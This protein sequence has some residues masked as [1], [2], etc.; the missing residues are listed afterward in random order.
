MFDPFLLVPIALCLLSMIA[1]TVCLRHCL[2]VRGRRHLLMG[3]VFALMS[4][5]FGT[6]ALSSFLQNLHQTSLVTAQ[7]TQAPKTPRVYFKEYQIQH[8]NLVN[9][10]MVADSNHFDLAF[11]NQ[12]QHLGIIRTKEKLPTSE[13]Y[14]KSRIN[15]EMLFDKIIY[16][17]TLRV[18]IDGK[19]WL[20]FRIRAVHQGQ[21]VEALTHVYSGNLGFYQMVA[22]SKFPESIDE[23]EQIQ[24]SFVFPKN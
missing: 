11:Q 23:L 3:I 2:G 6:W 5:V 4:L 16:G 12:G 21:A 20:K 9:W 22:W 17:D 13:L 15:L 24:Q 18:M 14:Q 7:K 19:A 10:S 1:M 8:P